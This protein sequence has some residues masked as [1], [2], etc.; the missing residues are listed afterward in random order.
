MLSWLPLFSPIFLYSQQ[1]LNCP[2]PPIYGNYLEGDEGENF[3]VKVYMNFIE[4]ENYEW[5][6]QQ[7]ADIR[8][9]RAFDYL[10]G[11]FNEIGIF[12]TTPGNPCGENIAE[13]FSE[14]D[15]TYGVS[16]IRGLVPNSTH[17]DGI[18][19]YF[20]D[21]TRLFGGSAFSIPSNF[22]L[23]QGEY[24]DGAAT[25]WAGDTP[26]LIHEMGHCLGLMHPD[27]DDCEELIDDFCPNGT[28]SDYCTG[29]HISDTPPVTSTSCNS[30]LGDNYMSLTDDPFCR[31]EFTEEQGQRMRAYLRQTSLLEDVQPGAD[32][33]PDSSISSPSGDIIV[34]SGELLIDS[35]LEMLPGASIIVEKG[36]TLRVKSTITGA[37]GK[38]WKGILVKGS[39]SSPQSTSAQGQVVVQGNNALIENAECAIRQEAATGGGIIKVWSGTLKNNLKGIVFTPYGQRSASQVLFANFTTTDAYLGE[40]SPVYISISH[41]F[42]AD[43]RYSHFTDER[44]TC[45]GIN[46]LAIGIESCNAGPQIGS[47][48]FTGLYRGV[49]IIEFEEEFPATNCYNNTFTR[50]AVGVHTSSSSNFMIRDNHFEVQAPFETCVPIEVFGAYLSDQTSG[51]V[52]ADNTF[53]YEGEGDPEYITTG[54]FCDGLGGGMANT[55]ERNTYSKL[56]YGNRADGGNADEFSG[57]LYLCNKYDSLLPLP[58]NDPTV[59]PA[60][61]HIEL[62]GSV[63][64]PQAI[65]DVDGEPQF[66][67]GN[68]FLDLAGRAFENLG[69][70]GIDYYYYDVPNQDPDGIE[71]SFEAVGI[72]ATTLSVANPNCAGPEPCAPPCDEEELAE[73][74]NN[75]HQNKATWLE[76]KAAYPQITD[77]EE[78]EEALKEIAGL[79]HHLNKDAKN[80]LTHYRQDTLSHEP[81]SV[82]HWLSLVESYP[83]DYRLA[84]HH[85]FTGK[86]YSFDNLWPNL[87]EQYG[88]DSARLAEYDDLDE[89]FATL[90]PYLEGGGILNQLPK[91]TINS[92]LYWAGQCNEAGALTRNVLFANGLR[93]EVECTAAP[94]AERPVAPY[95]SQTV[96]ASSADSQGVR[97]YPNPAREQLFLKLP[98]SSG[99][100][101][102][103]FYNL[104]GNVVY[105]LP[106]SGGLSQLPLPSALFK[107][108][109]Y[110]LKARQGG[111]AYQFKI[112]IY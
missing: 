28:T 38:L 11:V 88:L 59:L 62:N 22:L 27:R 33:F 93:L 49:N 99:L 97:A 105:R 26:V 40:D 65:R 25:H 103:I 75:F 77:E 24:D 20:L 60:A 74:K 37:C 41:S 56:S 1:A 100:G 6:D 19:L 42:G 82:L 90:R 51:F 14:I 110:L 111:T 73:A 2:D 23:L 101:L 50:C 68:E 48:T 76:K 89:V 46:N 98:E 112:A 9:K 109:V 106:L 31:V 32:E 43:I 83:A 18:D 102:A 36:A 71:T 72:F 54:T 70:M 35:P 84:R 81:D 55:I 12:F 8:A 21:D 107:P 64:N 67:T 53:T 78:Q 96:P 52:F 79:R 86:F 13:V 47:N 95:G 94:P 3:Q 10:N 29:D 104:Q 87:P 69:E 34:T 92:L 58:T 66:P 30:L 80:I 16:E 7:E 108:G 91:D 17:S 63:Q 39:F 45:P 57:L 15:T 5:I 61:I 44:S 4:Y 85:F